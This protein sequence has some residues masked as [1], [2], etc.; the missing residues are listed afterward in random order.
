[1]GMSNAERQKK[2]RERRDAYNNKRR[3]YLLKSKEKYNK[4]KLQGKRKSVKD[5]TERERRHQ[6]KL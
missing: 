3:E 2:F 6:R 5:M 1:M 4:D